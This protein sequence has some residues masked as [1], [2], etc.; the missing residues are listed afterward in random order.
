MG[1]GKWLAGLMALGFALLMTVDSARWYARFG[2]V[3]SHRRPTRKEVADPVRDWLDDHLAVSVIQGSY[4]DVY[5]LSFLTSGRVQGVP[6]GEYPQGFPEIKAKLPAARNRI[7]IIR[8][9]GVGPI[10]RIRALGARARE[11]WRGEGF[12]IV[13]WPE[14]MRP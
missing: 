1:G 2:W 3:D 13:Q 5:R 11:I 14:G 8:P 12:S 9:D 4:W 10:Y 7:M 6:F